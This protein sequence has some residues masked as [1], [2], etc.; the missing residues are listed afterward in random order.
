[1]SLFYKN[2]FMLELKNFAFYFK[3][4]SNI[5]ISY[6]GGLDSSVLLYQLVKLRSF[7]NI[8]IRAIHINHNLNS[9]SKKWIQHCIK[10]CKNYN[11]PILIKEVKINSFQ[12]G[13]ESEA[14]KKRYKVIIKNLKKKE[15]IVTGHHKNDQCE[16][17]LLALKRG[18]GPLGLSGMQKETKIYNCILLRPF[19]ENTKKQLEKFANKNKLNWIQDPS[20]ENVIHDRNFL[21][22]KIIPL[23]IKRWPYFYN[24]IIRSANICKEQEIL[25]DELLSDVFFKILKKNGGLLISYF[26]LYSFPKKC[27]LLRRW[28]RLYQ[29]QMPSRKILIQIL[30]KV[31]HISKKYSPCVQLKKYEIRKYKNTIYC[32]PKYYSLLNES[33][34]WKNP[35]NTIILPQNLG[36][37]SIEREKKNLEKINIRKPF[38]DEK[39]TIRFKIKGKISILGQNKEVKIKKIWQKLSI[40]VWERNRIP[41][42]F[43]N[44]K[45]ITAVSF[46]VTKNGFSDKINNSWNIVWKKNHSYIYK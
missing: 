18:S 33:I 2:Y 31:V 29:T 45:L 3:K 40:P 35:W 34:I 8:K 19:L 5:L 43:Y 7:T 23:F 46:F 38:K 4:Y 28:I 37:L 9:E 25:L 26:H 16:T 20:N 36:S 10:Q 1:M 11:V 15:V 24:T 41:F 12:E 22:K 17:I 30:D 32:I 13:I 21:R 6:S 44:E 27:A 14:R 42:I 39:V